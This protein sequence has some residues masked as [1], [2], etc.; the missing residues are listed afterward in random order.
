MK[1]TTLT[2]LF[3]WLGT[4]AL[5]QST[6]PLLISTSTGTY[7]GLINGT[8]PAVRQFLNIPYAQPPI[9]A[10]RWLP[11][12]APTTNASTNLDATHFPKSCAQYLSKTLSVYSQDVPEWIVDPSPY[13]PAGGAMPPSSAEDCLS[14]ALWTPTN[15]TSTSSLPVIMFM[16]GGGFNASLPYLIQ[17]LLEKTGV[18]S[19]AIKR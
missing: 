10:R 4:V 19:L 16:T 13:G 14:L 12:I 2:S 7:I 11:P 1:L 5:A 6:N 18:P 15:A 3:L 17:P 9:G 8:A